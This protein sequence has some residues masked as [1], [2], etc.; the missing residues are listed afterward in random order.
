MAVKRLGHANLH[1]FMDA[2]Q[3][4][5]DVWQIALQMDAEGQKI[6]DHDHAFGALSHSRLECAG[7]IGAALLEERGLHQVESGVPPDVIRNAPHRIVGRFDTRSMGENHDCGD[8]HGYDCS[9]ADVLTSAAVRRPDTQDAGIPARCGV[10]VPGTHLCWP[11]APIKIGTNVAMLA[12]WLGL[13]SINFCRIVYVIDEPRKYGFAYGTLP[14][15]IEAGEERF[16]VEWLKDGT[17]WY[18]VSAFSRARHVLARIAKPAVRALQSKFRR[19]S[20]RA[21]QAAVTACGESHRAIES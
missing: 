11:D 12:L 16:I 4:A 7:E 3:T 9:I 5:H 19:D 8:R 17:V 14:D 10:F 1:A 15:H 13:Y 21:M 6:R 2:R 20:G 18:D